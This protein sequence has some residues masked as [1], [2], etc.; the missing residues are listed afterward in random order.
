MGYFK[1]LFLIFVH[2]CLCGYVHGMG[3]GICIWYVYRC[4]WKVDVGVKFFRTTVTDGCESL[5]MAARTQTWV[6]W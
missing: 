2:M 6:L 3:I 1:D 4:L 5:N